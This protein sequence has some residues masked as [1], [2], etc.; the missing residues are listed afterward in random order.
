MVS[1]I[2]LIV[3]PLAVAFFISFFDRL[4]R[5]LSLTLFYAGLIALTAIS[6]SWLLSTVTGIIGSE[7]AI[8]GQLSQAAGTLVFT[9]GLEPPLSIALAMGPQEAFF[10]F[11]ANL[12][13]LGAAVVL[14]RRMA[15]ESVTAMVLFLMVMLGAQ[16]LV[17]TLDL[18]NLFVFLEISSIATYSLIALE[19]SRGSM[20]AGFK[21]IIAGGIASALFLIGTIYLY[22]I[23][24]SLAIA[25]IIA[26]QP[27]AAGM[28]GVT[29][30]FLLT[31]ALLIE[32]KPFPANGW[33]LDVYQSVQSG[34]VSV[35]AV[36][37][38]AAVLFAL[39]KV[40]PMLPA[41]LTNALL[42]IGI[43]TFF[44]SNLIGLRQSSVKRML[45]YSSSAQIGLL[46]SVLALSAMY[47]WSG[48]LQVIVFASIFFGHIFSKAGLFWLTEVQ[49]ERGWKGWSGPR[50][51][52]G[53]LLLAVFIAALAGL[54]P[55]PTFWAKWV[56]VKSII[57]QQPL[58][59]AMLLLGSLCEAV[60]LLRWFGRTVHLR[61]TAAASWNTP[62]R[63]ALPAAAAAILLT[64]G[65]VIAGLAADVEP[66]MFLPLAAGLVLGLLVW[67]PSRLQGFI[68]AALVTAA[69]A[70]FIPQM[71][72]M[73]SVFALVFYGGGLL[74]LI[75]TLYKRQDSPG[76]YPL[77]AALVL[78]LGSL[79]QATGL[80]EFFL[81]WEIMTFSSYFL[82]LLGREAEKPAL[83]YATFSV[84]GAFVLMSG[85]ALMAAVLPPEIFQGSL[86]AAQ[87]SAEPL[88]AAAP[89][90]I[91]QGR[92]VFAVAPNGF[93][94]GLAFT[95]IAI[96][97]LTKIGAAG[98]HIWLPDAYAEA[99]D[100]VTPLLSAVLSKAGIF[101]LMLFVLLFPAALFS[102][103]NLP[104]VLRWVGV[105]TAFFGTLMAVFEEDIKRVF[106]YSSMGQLGYIVLA[107]GLLNQL[108][109]TTALYLTVIHLLFKGMLFLTAT[110]VIDRTGT[111]QMYRMGGLIK[112]MPISFI[113]ALI[114]IIALSG[115]P[116]LA[117]FGG[118]WL[119]Y[120]ALTANNYVLLAAV[121]FFSSTIAFLYLFRFIYTVFLGQLK[122]EH[123]RVREA[124]AALL[125]PQVVFILALMA[126]SMFPNLLIQP[127][128]SA[129]A[130]FP[131]DAGWQNGTMVSSIGYWN[132]SAVMWITMSVFILM[133]LWLL[134]VQRKPQPVSQF[135]I[136]FAAERPERP[137]TTHYGYNFF[138]PYRKALGFLVTPLAG[139]FWHRI[140]EVTG[141][142]GGAARRIYTGNGQTYALH[143]LLFVTI[144]Y[145]LIAR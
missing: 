137:E 42:W 57:L 98:L 8:G 131:A 124:P 68:A 120:N 67:L 56:L 110:A 105:L 6:G 49:E 25:D 71:Q 43:T 47:G 134:F 108:G 70:L 46:I 32:L 74:M 76:F 21:Y 52:G 20:S 4:G 138:A 63:I 54:P 18:F 106:A 73:A 1:P 141:S 33:A 94:G 85:M 65:G 123:R 99:N 15:A 143:I 29:A 51:A 135:N 62:A 97:F 122:I 88:L 31:A 38:S 140:A 136:V 129:L 102:W 22:R 87:V 9:A 104:F 125:L 2:Y 100:D 144:L 118:K 78:S 50:A 82:I 86:I 96:G 112:N 92:D 19:R 72:G 103:F 26:A 115:V 45:G 53:V 80:L 114:A 35:I 37:N 81:A 28:A 44:A 10:L 128:Q 3:I 17:M 64:V 30:V 107:V 48:R 69:G 13:G 12:A 121:A 126:V 142:I 66:L 90:I 133:L 89:G 130:M 139:R 75:A 39:Y 111:R 16:G 84:G 41:P 119:L 34:V 95:L 91:G 83:N 23:A 36:V 58:V 79:I 93:L 55:F 127:L 116:P 14:G 132:G 7:G 113:S 60:Y 27:A 11:F 24:G 5:G 101:G 59:V 117:G 77:F 109:W 145:F 61:R 40:F